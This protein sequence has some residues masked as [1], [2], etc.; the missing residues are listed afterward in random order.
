M[1]MDGLCSLATNDPLRGC[2]MGCV[3]WEALDVRNETQEFG[4]L[5]GQGFECWAERAQTVSAR[6]VCVYVC[7]TEV[8]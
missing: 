4:G 7:V 2:R 1:R 8:S 5:V 6:A 3:C